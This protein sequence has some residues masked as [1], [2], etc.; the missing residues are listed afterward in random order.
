LNTAVIELSNQNWYDYIIINDDPKR[1]ALEIMN[2]IL[3]G[4]N[5]EKF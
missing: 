5:N 2:Y 1:A 3:K 4:E